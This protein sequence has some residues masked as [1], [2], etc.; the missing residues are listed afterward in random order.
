MNTALMVL[1]VGASS[2][3]SIQKDFLSRK[4]SGHPHYLCSEIN[5]QHNDHEQAKFIVV[6]YFERQMPQ[7]PGRRHVP[8]RDFIYY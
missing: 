2:E 3:K 6:R 4:Q 1:F 7:V 8:E 5:K